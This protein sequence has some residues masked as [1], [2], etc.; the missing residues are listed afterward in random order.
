MA[1]VVR[2]V[3][4]FIV[5]MVVSIPA[6][7]D[8]PVVPRAGRVAL[9]FDDGPNERW[10]PVILEILE[11]Y[12]VKAT[13]FVNGFRVER[14]PDVARAIVAAGHSLQNHTYGHENLP[15]LSARLV[16]W[17]LVEGNRAIT[18]ATGVSPNCVRPPWGATTSRV[19]A[20]ARSHDL[21]PVIWTFSTRD[22]VSQSASVVER[23]FGDIRD[24][25]VILMHDSI[26]WVWREALPMLIEGI[27]ARGLE[28][29]T[30]CVERPVPPRLRTIGL[31]EHL[32]V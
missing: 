7:A 5:V 14:R 11:R 17:S 28:F 21:E 19:D 12:D 8:V 9:T 1:R 27:R 23:S 6:R 18:E 30:I 3:T 20:I 29:D 13:F 32:P 22:Y 2:L 10:T 24:G 31:L 4:L 26:G 15:T 25:D 16:T